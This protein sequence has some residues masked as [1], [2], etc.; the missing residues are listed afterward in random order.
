MRA[1]F[2]WSMVYATPTNPTRKSLKS[3]TALA[4]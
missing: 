3:A 2:D 1:P 4:L